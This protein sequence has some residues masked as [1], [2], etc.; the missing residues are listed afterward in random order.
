MTTPSSP[1][2]VMSYPLA[3]SISP[4]EDLDQDSEQDSDQDTDNEIIANSM[5]L[6]APLS[7]PSPLIPKSNVVHVDIDRLN[8]TKPAEY[9]LRALISCETSYVMTK[10]TLIKAIEWNMTDPSLVDLNTCSMIELNAI[11]DILLLSESIAPKHSYPLKL[12]RSGIF[13]IENW[14]FVSSMEKMQFRMLAEKIGH[15]FESVELDPKKAI[16]EENVFNFKILGILMIEQKFC[17]NEI[18]QKCPDLFDKNY[19]VCQAT[20]SSGSSLPYRY[21]PLSTS[22]FRYLISVYRSDGQTKW[23]GTPKLNVMINVTQEL[24]HRGVEMRKTVEEIKKV[25]P[26]HMDTLS[27]LILKIKNRFSKKK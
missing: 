7:I 3:E 19:T 20:R 4:M 16:M 5:L 14:R 10:E 22:I 12:L 25:E 27:K 24:E 2:S 15:K 18:Y 23:C 8:L 26:N 9:L 17:L 13:I 11:Y 21:R 6:H 1:L